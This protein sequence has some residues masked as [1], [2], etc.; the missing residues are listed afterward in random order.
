MQTQLWQKSQ[1]ANYQEP[2]EFT[3]GFISQ[4]VDK[5]GFRFIFLVTAP[6]ACYYLFGENT[7]E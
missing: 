6:K 1:I 3:S 4:L 2:Q 5:H 7:I